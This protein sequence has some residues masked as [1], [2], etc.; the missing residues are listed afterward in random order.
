MTTCWD[1]ENKTENMNTQL[2]RPT[3]KCHKHLTVMNL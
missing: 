3:G 1:T 2:Q